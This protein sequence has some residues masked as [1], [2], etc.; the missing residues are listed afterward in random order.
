MGMH[1]KCKKC[2]V[3]FF[4]VPPKTRPNVRRWL[5]YDWEW[6]RCLHGVYLLFDWQSY[7]PTLFDAANKRAELFY[8]EV[9]TDICAC[10]RACVHVLVCL[11]LPPDKLSTSLYPKLIYIEIIQCWFWVEYAATGAWLRRA[12]CA[13]WG[14][15]HNGRFWVRRWPTAP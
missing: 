9:G 11:F 14:D 3:L 1:K 13:D 12:W 7:I 2:M 8:Q 6:P 15:P 10:V 4:L 5:E